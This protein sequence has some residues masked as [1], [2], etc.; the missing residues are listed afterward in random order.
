MQQLYVNTACCVVIEKHSTPL[1]AEALANQYS[2]SVLP[3]RLQAKDQGF[4]FALF[5]EKGCLKLSNLQHPTWQALHWDFCT[6]AFIYRLK[7]ANAKTELLLKALGKESI[8][9]V[10]DSTGGSGTD[11][12]LMASIG[13]KVTTCE[14]NP[15][16]HALL[17]DAITRGLEHTVLYPM[18]S[19][20]TLHHNDA[21]NLLNMPQNPNFTII[22]YDPMFPTRAKSAKVRKP[23]QVLQMLIG[24]DTDLTTALTLY[25][26]KARNRVIVKRPKNSPPVSEHELNYHLQS[27]STRFDIYRTN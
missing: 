9:S 26:K 12:V 20:I 6:S 24:Q 18:L 22:Y 23:M 2:L 25:I 7:K 13:L 10:L 21:Q 3:N 17:Q 5:Y 27:R 19:S 15:I 4:D 8:E 11:S 1:N 14:R 16:L